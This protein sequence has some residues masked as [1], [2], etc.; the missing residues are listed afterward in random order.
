MP[1]YALK[2]LL[3]YGRPSPKRAQHTQFKPKPIN[4]GTKSGTIIHEDPGKLLGDADKK[5]IQQGVGSFLYYARAI[6]MRILLALNDIA[7]QQA[8]PTESTMKI[9]HQLLDYEAM[10]PKAIIRFR[11]YNMI[12]NI[13]SDASYCSSGRGRS[14]AGGYFFLVNQSNS[15]ETFTLN[16][17]S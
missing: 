10:H 17:L 15:T 8:K 11:A 5:Y 9:V 3:T 7:T 14:R 16:V 6:D 1:N 4:Y 12:L 13:H 2:Q